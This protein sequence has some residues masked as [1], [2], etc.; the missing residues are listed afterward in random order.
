MEGH[1][2]YNPDSKQLFYDG[3]KEHSHE[4]IKEAM[5]FVQEKHTY[6]NRLNTILELLGV[7]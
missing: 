6:I 5:R 1:C 4:K 2:I 7:K 3:Q